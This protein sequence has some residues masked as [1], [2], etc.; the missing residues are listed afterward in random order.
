MLLGDNSSLNYSFSR[1]FPASGYS[2]RIYPQVS[3]N[4]RVAGTVPGP[5]ACALGL[6]ILHQ[7]TVASFGWM[8]E[9]L[10]LRCFCRPRD[11][12]PA[13]VYP[14]RTNVI[15]QLARTSLVFIKSAVRPSQWT[16]ERSSSDLL[17][18]CIM[19]SGIFL[20]GIFMIIHLL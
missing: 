2:V 12:S 1:F 19:I 11:S 15:P 3:S 17:I 13:Y 9:C 20:I 16:V 5:P 10:R 14:A 6:C 4:T 18:T 8:E 7:A